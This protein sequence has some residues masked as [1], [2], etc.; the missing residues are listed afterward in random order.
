MQ[1]AGGGV[2]QRWAQCQAGSREQKNRGESGW[3]GPE[4][5]SKRRAQRPRVRDAVLPFRIYIFSSLFLKYS[6][7]TVLC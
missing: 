2:G 4:G 3:K 6:W 5:R 7:L 1:K